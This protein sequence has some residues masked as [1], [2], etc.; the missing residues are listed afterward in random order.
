VRRG[1]Y[2]VPSFFTPHGHYGGFLW[3][4]IVAYLLAVAI[5]VPFINQTFYTGSLV[6]ALGG[7]DISWVVG[8]IAGT[9]FYLIAL[10]IP[11]RRVPVVVRA[12]AAPAIEADALD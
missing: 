8:G 7:A 1:E 11:D 12:A 3:R 4:G 5:E 9:V 10:R 2:D 6:K